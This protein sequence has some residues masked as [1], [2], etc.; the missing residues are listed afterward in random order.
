M[1]EDDVVEAG[2]EVVEQIDDLHGRAGGG[3]LRKANDVREEDGDGAEHL[4]VNDVAA[5]QFL[6]H[7]PAEHSGQSCHLSGIVREKHQ[8]I[9]L[10]RLSLLCILLCR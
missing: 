4:G 3:E 7:R 5:L 8:L 9:R 10:L 6:R 2:V 1:F